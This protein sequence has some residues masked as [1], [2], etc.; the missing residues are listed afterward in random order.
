[1]PSGRAG[2]L[3]R[4]GLGFSKHS[5]AKHKWQIQGKKRSKVGVALWAFLTQKIPF[6]VPQYRRCRIVRLPSTVSALV[7]RAGCRPPWQ[8]RQERSDSLV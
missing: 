1:M 7:R 4:N 5:F 3:Q 6:Y 8:L 2:N